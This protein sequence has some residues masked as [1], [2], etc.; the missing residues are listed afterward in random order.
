MMES[1]ARFRPGAGIAVHPLEELL[2]CPQ[3]VEN[4]LS[5]SS[6]WIECSDGEVVFFQQG[7]CQGLYLVVSGDFV[8][9]ARRMN[10]RLTL[11]APRA[12]D[13]VEL[14]AALGDGRHTYTLTALSAG[15]LLLLP[16]AALQRA[17][18]VYPP[19][20]MHLLEEL[21]REVS[22]VYLACRLTRVSRRRRRD[23]QPAG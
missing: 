15:S 10:A 7:I 8:R 16:I 9:K 17:F 3:E 22:R 6:Q 21:A 18:A 4:L 5:A 23:P 14:A 19:L 1:E 13:L 2:A 20:R 12:G 11:G